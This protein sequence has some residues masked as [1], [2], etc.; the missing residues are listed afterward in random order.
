MAIAQTLTGF[1]AVW[2]VHHDVDA[3]RQVARTLRHRVKS[4]LALG[5]FFHLEHHLFPRV[6]TCRL[7]ELADR[8][9]R[10]VPDLPKIPV[11]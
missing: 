8:L 11:Y 2:T 4:A 10:E 7:P 6:P 9:D 3:G 1:F 5:M